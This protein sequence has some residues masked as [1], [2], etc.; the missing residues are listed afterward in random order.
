MVTHHL[1]RGT[2]AA[3]TAVIAAVA[4]GAPP[5]PAAEPASCPTRVDAIA[6]T[7]RAEGFEAQAVKN[8]AYL[9]YRDCA[10]A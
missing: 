5:A 1:R 9:T 6:G 3:V 4:L 2:S 10:E 8:F 7:L